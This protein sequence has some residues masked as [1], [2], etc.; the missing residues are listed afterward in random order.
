VSFV[1]RLHAEARG[2]GK[3]IIL[4]EGETLRVLKA[5]EVLVKKNVCLPVLTG[6]RGNIE[7]IAGR[8]GVDL[9]GVSILDS[10]SLP[11]LER[12]ISLYCEIRKHKNISPEDARRLILGNPVYYAALGVRAGDFDGFV[13]GAAITTR[14]V[15]M[16]AIHCI[17][18]REGIKTISSS[19]IIVLPDESFG[20]RGIFIFADCGIVP[21][22]T[23]EQLRDIAIASSKTAKVLLE[24]E[25]KVA[26]L[27]YSTK[28]SGGSS[29]TI[30][31]VKSATM[32][33]RQAMPGLT[34]DGEVQVD[35]AI[36]PEVARRKDPDGRL[37]GRANVLIFPNLDAGNISYKITERLAKAR[38]IGPVLQGLARPA[39]DLSRGCSTSDIVDAVAVTVLR[40]KNDFA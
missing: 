35:T 21:D 31:K 26:M 6:R 16:A 33:V 36:V 15:A 3:K 17:G 1:E 24:D 20:S 29:E 11:Q 25:I 19:M 7:N 28:G 10:D 9:T 13:A 34:V 14:N 8:E 22:P 27:S 5:A 12:Y 32:M 38:A 4:P 30:E 40:S 2:S 37:K 23:P 18:P 39:S